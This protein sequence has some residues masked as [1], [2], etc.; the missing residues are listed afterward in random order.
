MPAGATEAISRGRIGATIAALEVSRGAGHPWPCSGCNPKLKISKHD[1]P[2]STTACRAASYHPQW[3]CWQAQLMGPSMTILF[4]PG[5][6]PTIEELNTLLDANNIEN[7][8]F[9]FELKFGDNYQFGL[10]ASLIPGVSHEDAKRWRRLCAK[11][12][13][14]L[15]QHILRDVIRDALTDPAG[16]IPIKLEFG[17]STGNW[18]VTVTHN[19]KT[20]KTEMITIAM[21]GIVRPAMDASEQA[22]AAAKKKK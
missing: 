18:G 5:A 6:K 7:T 14:P 17:P 9:E 13:P 10:L 12:I 21:T 11:V 20:G 4:K 22:T 3:L 19:G 2:T 16:P 8:Q 15:M 1:F